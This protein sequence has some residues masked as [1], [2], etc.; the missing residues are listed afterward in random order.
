MRLETTGIVRLAAAALVVFGA[1]GVVA[2][3]TPSQVGDVAPAGS[4]NGRVDADDVLLVMKAAVGDAEL[5][6]SSVERADVAP[7]T[8]IAGAP[9]GPPVLV[10]P[11][12]APAGPVDVGDAVVIARR[13]AGLIEFDRVNQA[14]TTEVSGDGAIVSVSPYELTGRVLDDNPIGAGYVEAWIGTAAVGGARPSV[15]GAT[16]VEGTF[17]VSVPLSRGVN[18]LKARTRDADG[19]WGPHS[20]LARV[21]LDDEP[22]VLAIT[23]PADLQ[24]IGALAVDFA[25]TV[26]DPAGASVAAGGVTAA[27]LPPDLWG[28]R[29]E[30]LD[31][32][33]NTI[34]V[35]ARDGAVPPNEVTLTRTVVR[36]TTP[37]SLAIDA[38]PAAVS[39]RVVTITG[40]VGDRWG[41]ASVTV[42]L[43]PAKI[44]WDATAHTG[45]WSAKVAILDG[46]NPLD[47]VATDVAGN[48]TVRKIAL[49]GDFT[50]PSVT[51]LSKEFVSRSPTTVQLGVSE[52][53]QLL[54]FGVATFAPPLEGTATIDVSGV[55]LNEGSNTL[56]ARVRDLAGNE[57]LA[58]VT[59][60]LD[61]VAPVVRI[62]AVK[63]A[64]FR[65]LPVGGLDNVATNAP[66][67]TIEGTVA[68]LAGTAAVDVAGYAATVD[69]T[70][71]TFTV[72]G[73]PL[74][75]RVNVLVAK[76][77]DEAGNEA[78]DTIR[79]KRDAEGPV[80]ALD[81]A[82]GAY[83]NTKAAPPAPFDANPPPPRHYR[84]NL[85]I[86]VTAAVSD[87]YYT[88]TVATAAVKL[89]GT[90]LQVF[91]ATPYQSF[92]FALPAATLQAR[93]LHLLE[94]ETTDG[95]GNK[96][97]DVQAM[98]NGEWVKPKS[99]IVNS[100]G[101]AVGPAA[102]DALEPLLEAQV[103]AINGDIADVSTTI[104]SGVT[105]TVYGLALCNPPGNPSLPPYPCTPVANIDLSITPAGH[106]GIKIVVPELHVGIKTTFSGFA[107][108]LLGCAYSRDG[109]MLAVP[110]TIT[111]EADFVNT[112][113]GVVLKE[114]AGS[115][116]V[117]IGNL[118]INTKH[119]CAQT[120]LNLLS[121][122]LGG[123]ESTVAS[124]FTAQV[125]TLLT[126]V[127]DLLAAPLF[128]DA[129]TG[130][131]LKVARASNS[132]ANVTL[133]MDAQGDPCPTAASFT[134]ILDTSTPAADDYKPCPADSP[135][136]VP[137]S[138]AGSPNA[139]A[140]TLPTFDLV[141]PDGLA[142]S[143]EAAAND[144]FVNYILHEQ[145]AMGAFD[146][147]IDPA[148]LGASSPI[149]LDT[150]ALS[151]FIPDFKRADIVAAVPLGSPVAV[152]TRMDLPP[153]VFGKA[154]AT[155]AY[156][157]KIGEMSWRFMADADGKASNGFE[158]HL[159]T[160]SVHIRA[161]A[162]LALVP[163]ATDNAD[164]EIRLL[165]GTPVI[166]TDVTANPLV[167][168]EASIRS[169]IAQLVDLALPSLTGGLTKVSLPQNTARF[170]TASLEGPGKDFLV[171]SGALV[172]T[173]T[174][175][176]PAAGVAT[177]ADPV[178]VGGTVD[179]LSNSAAAKVELWLPGDTTGRPATITARPDANSL[180]FRVS[181]AASVLAS[182]ANAGKVVATDGD[183]K[184]A[185]ATITLT[186]AAAGVT[187]SAGSG[188]GGC[189]GAGV[190]TMLALA[191]L[192]A[193]RRRKDR[194][195]VASVARV[196]MLALAMLASACGGCGEPPVVQAPEFHGPAVGPDPVFLVS[197]LAIGGEEDGFDVDAESPNGDPFPDNA[198]RGLAS[199]ANEP[200]EK[201]VKEG[202]LL[203]LVQVKGLS[204]LPAAGESGSF[205]AVAFLGVDTDRD[206]TDN[207]SGSEVFA[208]SP[209]S[210]DAQGQPLIR[211][212]S[213]RV[214][215][216]AEGVVTL[217]GGPSTFV[218]A[219]PLQGS[220]LSLKL[221]PTF[222]R[223]TLG[224]SPLRADG[225]EAKNGLLGGVLPA[226]PLATPIEGLPFAPLSVLA[227]E[228]DVD[229]DG[230][231][232]LDK[233]PTAE[234]KDGLSAGIV[235]TAVPALLTDVPPNQ[236]PAV[237][238][239]P[240]AETVNAATLRVKG[241]ARDPD[242]DCTKLALAVS[243]NG[244]EASRPVPAAAAEGCAFEAEVRLAVGDAKVRVT[245]TD[246]AGDA[247]S[248]EVSTRLVDLAAPV[249]TLSAPTGHVSVAAQQVRGVV[250]D[251]VGPVT[252]A[253]D[254]AGTQV[255]VPPEAIGA[256]GSFAV[257]VTL[258]S[259]GANVITGRAKDQGENVS[260]PARLDV[261]LDDVTAPVAVL[262]AL[263][264]S[265]GRAEGA[266]PWSASVRDVSIEGAV[267]DDAGT[268]GLAGSFAV[269]GGPASPVVFDPVDGAFVLALA[270]ERGSHVVRVSFT[271]PSGNTGT[272]EGSIV[273]ADATG[274]V[275][276][277]ESPA[278]LTREPLGELALRVNDD[279]DAADL[280]RVEASVG[281]EPMSTVPFDA[282]TATFRRPVELLAGANTLVV[283]AVD[284]AG[285]R[286]RLE[287]AIELLD[288]TPPLL[289]IT[290]PAEAPYTLDSNALVTGRAS[291]NAGRPRVEVELAGTTLP[292]TLLADGTFSLDV[293]LS[294]GMNELIVRA[295]DGAGL[296]TQ[297]TLR[298]LRRDPE[299]VATIELTP[300]PDVAVA[301]NDTLV[302][303]SA[304]LTRLGGG[305]VRDGT[306]VVFA[307]TPTDAGT[308]T[309]GNATTMGG[310]A[311]G[312]FRAGRTAGVVS[313]TATAQGLS[314][315]AS[316]TIA[317]PTSVAVDVC[318]APSAKVAGAS[319]E[320]GL[321]SNAGFVPGDPANDAT[322]GQGAAETFHAYN[323]PAVPT[324][325]IVAGT[326]EV[327][328][329]ASGVKLARLTWPLRS[330]FA[331]LADL[332]LTKPVVSD[333]DGR[334]SDGRGVLSV[335]GVEH[336][337]GTLPPR[338]AINPVAATVA[339]AAL[340]ISG[341]VQ[342]ADLPGCA[343]SIVVN[344]RASSLDVSTGAFSSPVTLQP[345][346][347]VIRVVVTD[348][349][350][351]QG[352]D[353]VQVRYVAPNLAPQVT[354]TSPATTVASASVEAAGTVSDADDGLA[355]LSVTVR[356]GTSAP[357]A[358]TVDPAAGTWRAPVTLVT[359]ANALTVTATDARGASGSAS[360]TTQLVTPNP[361]PRITLTAPADG[362]S[363]TTST[364]ALAGRVDDG[365]NAATIRV[366]L[367]VNGTATPVTFS[368]FTRDLSATITLVSGTN[369]LVV[370]ATDAL[371]QS[372]VATRRVDLVTPDAPPRITITSPS[373][374]AQFASSTITVRG[375]VR[376][377]KP[378]SQLRSVKVNGTSATVD[379]AAGTW[380]ATVPVAPGSRALVAEVVDER[381][382]SA[383]AT[384]T[385]QALS[386]VIV[387]SRIAI[388]GPSDGFN[389]DSTPPHALS[390]AAPDNALSGLA[391]I[392]N[393][394]LQDAVDGRSGAPLLLLFELSGLGQLPAPGQSATTDL[395][396]YVGV[397]GDNDTTDNFN[398][399]ETFTIDP[400]SFDAAGA[401]LIRFRNVVITNDFGSYKFDTFPANPANFQL[402]ISGTTPPLVLQTRPAYVR[403]TLSVRGD[404]FRLEPAL[405]GGVVPASTLAV[406][407]SVGT[408]SVVPLSLILSSNPSNPVPD[409]DLNGDGTV[410]T[411]NATSTNPDGVSVGIV[412]TGVSCRISR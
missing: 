78:T 167:V 41:V 186:K 25:G 130:R 402:G 227:S 69:A 106:V 223:A 275:I 360:Q 389:V 70:A 294:M 326:Q 17:S 73:V 102:L 174:I 308:L 26:S 13:A 236:A 199:L 329:G 225:V 85:D 20:G 107:W 143:A 113:T 214:A 28:A 255:L 80:V 310:V 133:W 341:T 409:V 319:F 197:S 390:D 219:V 93:G 9:A 185:A 380:S 210:F 320:L 109:Y 384:V 364:V 262:K 345:G 101:L 108:S 196:L 51:R 306:S 96:T 358:A 287:G 183:G 355:G 194:R 59:V 239:E 302:S 220:L 272:V 266:G 154:G 180:A 375:T 147:K 168:N 410:D 122:I 323:R 103:A 39:T 245:A 403:G 332:K 111:L 3:L 192:L 144:E 64:A 15:A 411:A 271:D 142:T 50:P 333:L 104:T 338:V 400:A 123:L 259:L 119:G 63:N 191:G 209:A 177:T 213:V 18:E 137:G 395:V 56:T 53:V 118:T 377:D 361:P 238:L 312:T 88:N 286:T 352:A 254:V 24:P 65:F 387:A 54:S 198:L 117:K 22:P 407:V 124:L 120:V 247:G 48:R 412:L 139:D 202:T 263:V 42:G 75:P 46:A 393:A 68:D 61:T 406:P 291:D 95:F 371:S 131:S 23:A 16:A 216:D 145:W 347:N 317:A 232:R 222:I 44:V 378:L 60:V 90:T 208:K 337:V 163:A 314:D 385:V 84:S 161:P 12:P 269:D 359:G 155:P 57:V 396:G 205:E 369:V 343:G 184:K 334:T 125:S 398:G 342:A 278:P 339:S 146:L 33:A 274:P 318:V 250:T 58:D 150:D 203:L 235:F 91:G 126:S 19:R 346:A 330:G 344:G 351:R 164:D 282:V 353:E 134:N 2:S 256:D 5:D 159:F 230:D 221:S 31:E 158:T 98:L 328:G 386:P 257:E 401:P 148:F 71:G 11:N 49:E 348:A 307:A 129:R 237:T 285:N 391:S 354:I 379:A 305:P 166:D 231:R 81:F 132:T 273:V 201:A 277:V 6:P 249:L 252:V 280:L 234:N 404:G 397:D 152:Q 381:G 200:L 87:P 43:E 1:V 325:V 363:T 190:G 265:A 284:T 388:G 151:L 301:G 322:K 296:V 295:S 293:P 392:A 246:A 253:L 79:V 149:S 226:G 176:L 115:V 74:V 97:T 82:R 4:P 324:A 30:L 283:E 340:V 206:P 212:A 86:T 335:C 29:V 349:E 189:D 276:S 83:V 304:L 121:F 92:T 175:S 383:T 114:R 14:P 76:A 243:V 303:L 289:E 179:G 309:I 27:L 62:T 52:P 34:A 241:V 116:A 157:L 394:P 368:P 228:I 297:T 331:A 292:A 321:G 178:V 173:I 382:Q 136:V 408:L 204:H 156:D 66:A 35:T 258:P 224:V 316:L 288:E 268:S 267:A 260:E 38:L 211:F 188:C 264:T 89:D 233:T 37:P 7:V 251:D 279:W 311:M 45:R 47:V 36:D 405:L 373:A 153:V 261:F 290:G 182:G 165:L 128:T 327:S 170:R 67:V 217:E 350:G 366:V 270:L 187:R 141:A 140:A 218:L 10:R 336:L 171:L 105:L 376:D 94:I 172:Q 32:D 193:R 135:R 315:G 99:A 299:E 160:A 248:A 72:T 298:I 362:L 40:D 162:N 365:G 169:A 8:A 244:T 242:G 399:A 370:T 240:V 372:A 229:L 112:A 195:A 300:S 21:T 110:A 77:T 138:Y 357:V 55:V 207:L 127:N 215:A 367:T 356:V 374:G 281:A 181:V 100:V 313:L